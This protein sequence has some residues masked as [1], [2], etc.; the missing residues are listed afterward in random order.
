MQSREWIKPAGYGAAG[1]ALALAIIGFTAGGWV[2]GGTATKMAENSD[3]NAV[4]TVM[5]P[6]CVAQSKSA[7][8]SVEVLAALKSANS[9]DRRSIIEK[10]GWATPL[11]NT[12]PNTALAV[13]CN[14]ALALN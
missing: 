12:T 6:Y 11:G 8:N 10:A 9:Y 7:P 4:V 14:S 5:T 1:G 2:T 13:S 3:T